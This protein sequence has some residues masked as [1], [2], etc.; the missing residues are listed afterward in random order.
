MIKQFFVFWSRKMGIVMEYE[1]IWNSIAA[2][3]HGEEI[4]D[5][6]Q[7]ELRDWLE[8][9]PDN[10]KIYNRLYGFYQENALCGSVDIAKAWRKNQTQIGE[11][12]IH[13]RRIF[14]LMGWAASVILLAG[15]ALALFHRTPPVLSEKNSFVTGDTIKPGSAKATL[16]LASGETL[17]LR[18]KEMTISGSAG[19]IRNED[20][21]LEYT[22]L[23]KTKNVRIEYNTLDIPRG[24]EYCLKLE[25]G[26]QVWL[27]ADTRLRYPVVFGSQ[28]RR[29]YLEGEAYFQVKKDASRPFIVCADGV[30]ITAL[31]T[32]FNVSCGE[33]AKVYT[34][35]VQGSVNVRTSKGTDWIL[36]PS[37]Q[38]ICDEDGWEVKVK[39]VKTGLYTSWKD[40]YYTFEQQPLEEIMN[41]L[42]RW[43]DI[44]VFFINS[45]VGRLRFSGRLRRYD[46]ISNLLTM[47]KLTNDVNFEIKGKTIIVNYGKNRKYK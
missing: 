31:G 6:E 34:T 35:L 4:S 24:G 39:K 45:E 37:E 5:R 33:N 16:T 11:K 19:M 13:R 42:S 32:E 7:K 30:D 12:K 47:I 10:Q 21:V 29:I 17:N 14:R 36:K 43:Y 2:Q 28:E 38:A 41:T 40:G 8:A 3:I 26:T 15:V 23:K 25:D 46:D 44:H 9:E 18:E 27:N 1:E 22:T 20:H